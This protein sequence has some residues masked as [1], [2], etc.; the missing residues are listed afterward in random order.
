[1][2]D[3]TMRALAD[4]TRR[5][6]LRSLRE[7]DLSAGDIAARFDMTAPSISHHL[8]VLKEA[9]LVQ[10]IRDGRHII[11]SLN[12]TVFQDFMQ[13]FLELMQKSGG[14]S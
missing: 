3:E 11:Y 7:G 4:P 8:N 10:A 9:G 5:E 14:R 6:I 1:V 12:S 13:E 2:I